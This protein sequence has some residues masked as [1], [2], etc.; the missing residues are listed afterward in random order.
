MTPVVATPHGVSLPHD[1]ESIPRTSNASLELA[2][3]QLEGLSDA[4]RQRLLRQALEGI[5]MPPPQWHELV[6]QQGD[7]LEAWLSGG[8]AL[9]PPS[10]QGTIHPG[11]TEK[12]LSTHG[13]RSWGEPAA[14]PLWTATSR[15]ISPTGA[16]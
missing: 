7:L 13:Q 6:S 5:T 14:R 4:E 9:S 15:P 2:P 10:V 12:V 3:L 1:A 8:E 11:S 16:S